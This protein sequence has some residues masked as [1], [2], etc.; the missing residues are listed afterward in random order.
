MDNTIPNTWI[1]SSKSEGK[2]L[3]I[4]EEPQ[5]EGAWS[6]EV[7][8]FLSLVHMEASYFISEELAAVL[9]EKD[10]RWNPKAGLTFWWREK[11][12]VIPPIKYR[13]RDR[14]VYLQN[15]LQIVL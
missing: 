10:V 2:L 5:R 6:S 8:S 15:W 14:L 7:Q 4:T 12:L 9:T 11:Y 3:V 1:I 13:F